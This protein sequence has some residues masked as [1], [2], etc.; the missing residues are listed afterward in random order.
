MLS[1]GQAELHTHH[2]AKKYQLIVNVFQA[3]ILCLF[4][5]SDILSCEQI[6]TKL[7]LDNELFE[8]AMLKL[9]HPKTKVLSK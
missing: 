6:K 1:F 8:R 4:N 3:A 7:N 2:T 9:C 5:E